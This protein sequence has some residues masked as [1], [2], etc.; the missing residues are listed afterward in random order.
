MPEE[1]ATKNEMAW[2][3][4]VIT[5][6]R[7][8]V[9][10]IL[11]NFISIALLVVSGVWYIHKQEQKICGLI[12]TFDDTYQKTPPT[13]EVGRQIAAQMHSYRESIGCQ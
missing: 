1:E 11:I 3:S 10:A 5:W 12:V 9:Y 8:F 6:K 4:E 7:R 13:T 2:R